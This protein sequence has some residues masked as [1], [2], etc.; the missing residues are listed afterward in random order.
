MK[1]PSLS[2]L[3]YAVCCVA[4]LLSA[5]V[6]AGDSASLKAQA[7]NLYSE[8]KMAEKVVPNNSNSVAVYIAN[9]EQDLA[10]QSVIFSVD[11]RESARYNY[12]ERDAEALYNGGLHLLI[13]L[14][15]PAGEHKI[16]AKF[17]VMDVDAG[18]HAGRL[19]PRFEQAISLKNDTQLKLELVRGGLFKMQAKAEIR[20]HDLGP[21]NNVGSDSKPRLKA[22]YFNARRHLAFDALADAIAIIKSGAGVALF[23]DKQKQ[24]LS[25]S[26]AELGLRGELPELQGIVELSG[27]D[28]KTPLSPMFARYNAGVALIQQ[29]KYA[30][31]VA[32]LVELSE[33]ESYPHEE[34]LLRD[35]INLALGFHFLKQDDSEKSVEYFSKV[36]R[37]SP[38]ANKALVGLGWAILTPS[39]SAASSAENDLNSPGVGAKSM[40]YLWSG[41]EDEIAWA[42]R[43]APFRRAWAVAHGEKAEDL[44][45]A[46]V[47]W[48]E[49][50]SRDPLDPA[51]QEGLL[52]LPYA[53]SHWAGQSQRAEKYYV[54][55][56]DQLQQALQ[57]LDTASADIQNG[58]LRGAIDQ[59]DRSGRSGWDIWLSALT[60][61]KDAYLDLLLDSSEF[62]RALSE[63]RQLTHISTVLS[64]YQNT[65]MADSRRGALADELETLL[66]KLNASAATWA[67]NLDREALA[68]ISRHRKRTEAYLAEANFAL[69][70]N[71]ENTRRKLN[72]VVWDGE[73]RR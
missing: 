21:E 37:L 4:L 24:A 56:S 67:A 66:L 22:A 39:R 61:S 52:I 53:M 36:R 2:I 1:I 62:H 43:H 20:V 65:F 54:S 47:P 28:Q 8:I 5:A 27:G 6:N 63:Y 38:Y 13:E 15:L 9:H 32:I 34:I 30:E 19:Y 55:A 10:I 44:Q 50:I 16:A 25:Q 58:G 29:G 57:T 17:V 7:L 31:G 12:S 11:G 69:A 71:H 23:S 42:R 48:M 73:A 40:P 41:N 68:E 18:I 45:A 35:K 60:A 64:E 70:R 3:K 59:A 33:G 72:D 51:V 14:Q 49:L 26:V 46:M